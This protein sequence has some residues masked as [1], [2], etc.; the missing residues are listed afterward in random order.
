MS[1]PNSIHTEREPVAK[2]LS[3]PDEPTG[4]SGGGGCGGCGCGAGQSGE[5]TETLPSPAS[6]TSHYSR[7]WVRAL[8]EMLSKSPN[9]ESRS[10]P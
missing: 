1:D 3:A 6:L 9:T 7:I 2:M 4:N 8:L 10:K 5:P